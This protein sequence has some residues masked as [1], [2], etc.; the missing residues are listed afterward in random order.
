MIAN[1]RRGRATLLLF[2]CSAGCSHSSPPANAINPSLGSASDVQ[3]VVAHNL[4]LIQYLC[5]KRRE[6]QRDEHARVI[7]SLGKQAA[8]YLIESLADERPSQVPDIFYPTVGDVA[9]DLLCEI[10]QTDAMWIFDGREP[11]DMGHGFWFGDYVALVKSRGGREKL[12]Q[13][14]QRFV[15]SE[16]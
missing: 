6:P 13:I 9:H 7:V 5:P 1:L 14:W 2:V 15:R 12:R 16:N 11:I 4:P 8:P 3:A 10:Y